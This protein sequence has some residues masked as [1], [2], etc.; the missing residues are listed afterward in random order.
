MNIIF[1]IINIW[2]VLEKQEGQTGVQQLR[3]LAAL[4]EDRSLVPNTG[5]QQLT[6]A[7]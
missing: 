1:P 6:I 4:T 7:L 3:M 2:Q 5:M